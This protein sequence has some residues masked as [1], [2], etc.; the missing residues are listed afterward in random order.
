M[1]ARCVQIAVNARKSPP[2]IRI[3]IPGWLPNLK[4]CPLFALT[5][6]GLTDRF[7]VLVV[8]SSTLGGIMYL[9]TGYRVEINNAPTPVP[10]TS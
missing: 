7:T 8:D 3:N 2:G 10:K 4:I 1:Q 9:V 6:P 5:S